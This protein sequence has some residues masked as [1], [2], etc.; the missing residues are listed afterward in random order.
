MRTREMGFRSSFLR[1]RRKEV[2]SFET[3]DRAVVWEGR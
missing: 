1:E 2:T 3:E